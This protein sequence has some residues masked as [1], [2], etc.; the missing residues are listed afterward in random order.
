MAGRLFGHAN[1]DDFR[2]GSHRWPAECS[3]RLHARGGSRPGP[4]S[5][6]AWGHRRPPLAVSLPADLE[7]GMNK[8]DSISLLE[9]RLQLWDVIVVGA[10]PAGALAAYELARR[11][12]RVLLVGQSAFPRPQVSGCCLNGQAFAVL[13]VRGPSR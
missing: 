2:R 9:V 4:S 12:L 11:S 6:P 3:R 13:P 1:A 8:R 7:A 5:R 10:G